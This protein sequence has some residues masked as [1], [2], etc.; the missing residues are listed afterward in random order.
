MLPPT[1]VP[2]FFTLSS[3]FINPLLPGGCYG[4]IDWVVTVE[5]GYG[6]GYGVQEFDSSQGSDCGEGWPWSRSGSS[7]EKARSYG[8]W[9][10]SY[11]SSL[12]KARK[13]ALVGNKRERRGDAEGNE[14]ERGLRT[15]LF[16]I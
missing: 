14:R 12:E 6:G 11:G 15:R 8:G 13:L 10:R 2:Y 4:S 7:P 3:L 16:Y 5:G 9:Q 1:C